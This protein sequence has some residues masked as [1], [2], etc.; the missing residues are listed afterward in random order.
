M[1]MQEYTGSIARIAWS[2][3][4]AIDPPELLQQYHRKMPLLGTPL[5]KSAR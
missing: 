5:R 4:V 2:M 1:E 3:T